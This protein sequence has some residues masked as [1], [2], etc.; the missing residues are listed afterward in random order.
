MACAVP[1]VKPLADLYTMLNA[2]KTLKVPVGP[3]GRVRTEVRIC[4]TKTGPEHRLHRGV[5]VQP[6]AVA[7]PAAAPGARAP[8]WCPVTTRPRSSRSPRSLSQDPVML[9]AYRSGDPY[10]AFARH[11]GAIP[12]GGRQ[13]HAPGRPG[14]V[15][16]H[17]LARPAT[18]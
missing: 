5:P 9:Q 18:A 12:P 14:E 7:P 16:A 11:V 10:V 8:R 2:F 17:R 13:D 1:T 6:R 15:Q 3:D 4:G